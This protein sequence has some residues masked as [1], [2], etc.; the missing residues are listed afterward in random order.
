MPKTE[1]PANELQRLITEW[2]R[3][4]SFQ[5]LIKN[6]DKNFCEK[7]IEGLITARASGCYA[8]CAMELEELLKGAVHPEEQTAI[9]QMENF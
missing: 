1:I 9:H 2:K 3:R 6:D 8:N 4:A 7:M 5:V